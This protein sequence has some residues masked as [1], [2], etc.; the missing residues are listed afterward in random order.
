[1]LCC[2]ICLMPTRGTL[3][4]KCVSTEHVQSSTDICVCIVHHL[5]FCL[6]LTTAV[7]WHHPQWAPGRALHRAT[8]CDLQ[9]RGNVSRGVCGRVWWNVS[10][11]MGAHHQVRLW[12]LLVNGYI[13][14]LARF[15]H[16]HLCTWWACSCHVFT[17]TIPSSVSLYQWVRI[18]SHE[19]NADTEQCRREI[20]NILYKFQVHHSHLQ[21]TL[22]WKWYPCLV[23]IVKQHLVNITIFIFNIWCVSTTL[24]AHKEIFPC[25][26]RSQTKYMSLHF[27]VCSVPAISMYWFRCVLVVIS[28]LGQWSKTGFHV[29]TETQMFTNTD[30]L[31][32]HEFL[33]RCPRL[34]QLWE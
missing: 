13:Y 11:G 14:V 7:S 29:P 6:A 2:V 33:L 4:S 30:F 15:H 18:H 10:A 17:S 3:S 23:G 20:V 12:C 32:S 28:Q 9:G 22:L 34:E 25:R 27:M 16:L 21:I 8:V 24:K 5:F 26:N 31:D 1:M 19:V